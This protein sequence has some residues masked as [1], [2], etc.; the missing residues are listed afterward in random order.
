MRGAA[1]ICIMTQINKQ[2]AAPLRTRSRAGPRPAQPQ[3]R[4]ADAPPTPR[5]ALNCCRP[6]DQW[7]VPRIFKAL[8][9]PTRTTLLA[10]LAKCGRPCSVSEVAQCC[11]VDFSVVSRHLALLAECDILEA[12]KQ[13]RTVL[14]R[15]RYRELSRILRSLADAIDECCPDNSGGCCV[16]R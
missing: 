10:C 3:K 14:Y 13:G 6:I 15:V 12:D 16:S 1:I 8:G 9:D 4:R 7:L 2:P 5:L 11:S